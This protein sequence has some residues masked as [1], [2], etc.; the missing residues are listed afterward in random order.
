MYFG[1]SRFSVLEHLGRYL[2]IWLFRIELQIRT[3]FAQVIVV[4]F[5]LIL[6]WIIT[7]TRSCACTENWLRGYLKAGR[8]KEMLTLNRCLE[9]RSLEVYRSRS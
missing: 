6:M 2:Y 1:H 4:I 7:V 8:L 5:V 3:T 9:A